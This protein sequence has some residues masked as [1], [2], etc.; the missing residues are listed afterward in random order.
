[1]TFCPVAAVAL[2]LATVVNETDCDSMCPKGL[3]VV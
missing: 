1:M 2:A 3:P